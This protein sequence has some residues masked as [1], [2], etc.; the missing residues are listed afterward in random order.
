MPRSVTSSAIDIAYNSDWPMDKR[1]ARIRKDLKDLDLF[2]HQY[3]KNAMECIRN[4][5]ANTRS[6]N[7]GI[8]AKDLG[9]AREY[10][11]YNGENNVH[12][13]SLTRILKSLE[14]MQRN[15]S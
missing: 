1:I 7:Y 6:G 13:I 9:K 4:G 5:M 3:K 15:G 10:L 2:D 12:H 14:R 8:A 11:D